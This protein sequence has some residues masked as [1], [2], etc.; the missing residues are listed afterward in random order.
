MEFFFDFPGSSEQNWASQVRRNGGRR[1]KG[2]AKPNWKALDDNGR[3]RLPPLA[4]FKYLSGESE[5]SMTRPISAIFFWRQ[6]H[7]HFMDVLFTRLYIVYF[8]ISF[9]TTESVLEFGNE[10]WRFCWLVHSTENRSYS[11]TL[12]ISHCMWSHFSKRV[13]LLSFH[14][15]EWKSS[16]VDGVELARRFVRIFESQ[17]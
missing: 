10:T 2:E 12:N 7:L 16:W 13:F 5:K 11:P 1:I 17:L 3:C 9:D 8:F 6:S 4:S 14:Y 15:I